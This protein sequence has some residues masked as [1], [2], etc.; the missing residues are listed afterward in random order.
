[1]RQVLLGLFCL[2]LVAVASCASTSNTSSTQIPSRDDGN[3]TSFAVETEPGTGT[4]TPVLDIREDGAGATVVVRAE[5]AADLRS[6]FVELTY[7]TTRYTPISVELSEFLGPADNALSL[8]LT[9]VA[10]RVPI[11]IVQLDGPA[12]RGDGELATVRFESRPFM[13]RRGVSQAPTGQKNSVQDLQIVSIDAG[14]VTLHWKEVNVGDYNNNGEVSGSDLAPI[15][16]YFG[17]KVNDTSDP[18][19]AAIIDGDKNGEVNAA[20]ISPIAGNFGNTITGYAAYDDESGTQHVSDSPRPS[21]FNVKRPVEYTQAVPFSGDET[22]VVRP[23]GTSN[24]DVGPPSNPATVNIVPGPP[25]AP[26]NLAAEVGQSVGSKKVRLNW[27]ASVSGDVTLYEVERK[28]ASDPDTAFVMIG[29]ATGTTYLDQAGLDDDL[30]SYRVRAF[31]VESLYSDYSA[32]I[33]AQPYVFQLAVPTGVTA[34]PHPTM[35]AAIRVSWTAAPGA[36][37]HRVYGRLQGDP[38]FTP[39]GSYGSTGT[40]HSEGSLSEGATYEFYVV[41]LDVTGQHESA[42]S[43]TASSQCSLAT[44]LEINS[45]TTD[46]TTHNVDGSEGPSTITVLTTTPADSYSWSSTLGSV[47]GTGNVVTW[48]PT[49]S[50]TP[51][52]VT[53]SVT[54]TK[55]AQSD[56]A[57]IDLILTSAAILTTYGDAGK[58]TDFTTSYLEPIADGGN[59]YQHSYNAVAEGR[60]VLI[61]FWDHW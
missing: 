54:A 16:L 50:P 22:Y 52:K 48:V 45:I 23:M 12:V 44:Q 2:M 29:E 32:T 21:S 38:T 27:D 15:A 11:S 31:D 10:G 51:Q 19:H 58:A 43:A 59:I 3:Q 7:D 56:Q 39:R 1:M 9:D 30:Y 47:T 17:Q 24:T 33:D 14:S 34:I 8:T 42:P 5:N 55:G 18:I 26:T 28:L 53:I 40:Q 60:V 37:G 25:E 35:S 4:F 13:A 61:K 49:G 20:D 41:A 57:T 46:K 6:A 36:G